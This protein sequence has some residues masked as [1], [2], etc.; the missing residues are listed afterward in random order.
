AG[1]V[2]AAAVRGD[3]G[4]GGGALAGPGGR[5]ADGGAGRGRCGRG[6]AA[7]AMRRERPSARTWWSGPTVVRVWFSGGCSGCLSGRA[8]ELAGA[9]QLEALVEQVLELL[10]GAALEQHVPVGALGLGRLGLG[11]LGVPQEGLLAAA[12]LPDRGDV[13]VGGEGQDDGVAVGAVV[14][15]LEPRG[16]VHALVGLHALATDAHTAQGPVG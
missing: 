11:L 1:G 10:D 4:G 12:A 13:R 14:V 15:G 8:A 2:A 9:Q 6:G 7:P 3:A 16:E 5:W